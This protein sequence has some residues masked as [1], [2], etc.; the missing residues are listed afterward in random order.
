MEDEE[1]S[2]INVRE[3]ALSWRTKYEFY[4][5][6]TMKGGVYLPPECNINWDFIS[7]VID[8]TKKVCF[9]NR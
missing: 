7:D 4:Q 6:M 5:I 3:L 2:Y 1:Q 9:H 8:G